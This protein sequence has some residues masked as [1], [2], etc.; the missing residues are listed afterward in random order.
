M[1]TPSKTPAQS[2]PR[3]PSSTSYLGLDVRSASTPARP[4]QQPRLQAARLAPKPEPGR[5]AAL[6]PGPVRQRAPPRTPAPAL[7]P[8][9]TRSL[10]LRKRSCQCHLGTVTCRKARV[11]PSS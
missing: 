4:C 8:A 11:T 1:Q 10:L 9:L 7:H 3:A 5:T 2:A 6:R